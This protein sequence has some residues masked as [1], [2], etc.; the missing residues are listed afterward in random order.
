MLLLLQPYLT[1][2]VSNSVKH[3]LLFIF[4]FFVLFPQV[5]ALQHCC[6]YKPCLPELSAQEEETVSLVV[7]PLTLRFAAVKKN[8]SSLFI[9]IKIEQNCKNV[10]RRGRHL[11]VIERHVRR[12]IKL[13]N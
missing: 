6:S 4:Y 13:R 3:F 10:L 1:I 5:V 8:T 7:I 11:F 2:F 9:S 12:V